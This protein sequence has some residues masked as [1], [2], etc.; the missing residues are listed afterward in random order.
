M[1]SGSGFRAT[2][3][4]CRGAARAAA[5]SAATARRT[6]CGSAE[7]PGLVTP[8][9]DP[10][11]TGPTRLCPYGLMA[12]SHQACRGSPRAG[13]GAGHAGGSAAWEVRWTFCSTGSSATARRCS[14]WTRRWSGPA[15]SA[16]SCG[17]GS[18]PRPS[19]SAATRTSAAKWRCGP[20]PTTGCRCCGVPPAAGRSTTTSAPL[21]V[22]LVLPGLRTTRWISGR[23]AAAGPAGL[24]LAGSSGAA[25]GCSWDRSSWPASRPCRPARARWPTPRP[26]RHRSGGGRPVPRAGARAAPLDSHRAPVTSLRHLG[27]DVPVP[28]LASI[29]PTRAGEDVLARAPAPAERSAHEQLLASRYRDIAWHLTGPT[30]STGPDEGGSMDDSVRMNLYRTMV[31]IRVFE[32]AILREYHADKRPAFDIGAGLIPGEMHLSAGQEP[33]AAGVCAHLT[34]DDAVTATHRPHH[35]AIAHG[36]DLRALAGGDLRPGD[37]PRPRPRRAHAPVR[38]GDALLLL[39]HHRRGP[40][41]GT[42]AG[43]RVPHGEAPTDRGRRRPARARRTRARSTSR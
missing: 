19:S 23:P 2:N 35:L 33:V 41:A 20:A 28:E 8:G 34:T 3:S 43:V 11:L 14:R 17:P 13:I 36:M 7:S 32:E 31:L 26:G 18:A 1:L 42:R 6:A 38:P 10:G 39:R 24:G 29:L 21:N 40:A 12:L 9:P 30:F 4:T 15:R 27:V 22:A 16:R 25:A 37:G 5:A